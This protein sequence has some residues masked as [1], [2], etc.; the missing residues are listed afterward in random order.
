[1]TQVG[2]NKCKKTCSFGF[3]AFYRS[4]NL[5]D[6]SAGELFLDMWIGG[7]VKFRLSEEGL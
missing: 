2:R 4:C 1:M 6:L 3:G 5:K 7:M